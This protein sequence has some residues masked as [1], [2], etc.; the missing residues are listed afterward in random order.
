MNLFLAAAQIVVG[1]ALVLYFAS[2]LVRGTAG[3]AAGL[4]VS[5]FVLSVV[6]P[7]LHDEAWEA[8]GV[9]SLRIA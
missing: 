4:G 7:A 1:V 6:F 3:L 2:R 5:A 9:S 8:G